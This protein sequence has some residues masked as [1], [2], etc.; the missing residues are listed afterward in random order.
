MIFDSLNEILDSFR[1]F[2]LTGQ[3]YPWKV[4][5]KANRPKKITDD[6]LDQVLEKSRIRVLEWGQFMCGYYGEN[7]DFIKDK[8]ASFTEEYLSQVKEDRLSKMLS[9]DV[10]VLG[11]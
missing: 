4:S 1:P 9:H 2:G 6:N 10:R 3:P 5:I 7:D 11:I 8:T